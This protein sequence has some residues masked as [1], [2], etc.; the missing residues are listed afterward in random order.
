MCKPTGCAIGI[1]FWKNCSK[2]LLKFPSVAKSAVPLPS[3]GSVSQKYS[4]WERVI[5]TGVCVCSTFIIFVKTGLQTPSASLTRM[6]NLWIPT[7][8]AAIPVLDRFSKA[9]S[10]F[11]SV[12]RTVVPLPS[13]GSVS[14]KYSACDSFI[15]TGVCVCSTFII[16][17]KTGLQ[18]VLLSFIR[19]LNVWI[20]TLGAAIPDFET[21]SKALS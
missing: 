1:P 20:P 11:P 4:A 9:V 7:L 8:G 19:I 17:V 16:F 6:L 2:A 10:K 5:T 12:A 21:C 15:T 14:Q 3:P 18:V 13:P